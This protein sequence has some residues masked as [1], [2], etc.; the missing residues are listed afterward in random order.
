[1]AMEKNNETEKFQIRSCFPTDG[2]FLLY[3]LQQKKSS[4]S[5]SWKA[6]PGCLL[7]QQKKTEY[8]L[9]CCCLMF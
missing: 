6:F 7:I 3:F 1:M 4:C 5:V 9:E 8:L 2:K